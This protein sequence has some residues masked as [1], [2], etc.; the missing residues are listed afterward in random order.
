[1]DA[2]TMKGFEQECGAP[3]LPRQVFVGGLPKDVTQN[4]L[5]AWAEKQFAGTALNAVLVVDKETHSRPRGFGFITFDSIESAER[6]IQKRFHEFNGGMIEIKRAVSISQTETRLKRSSG[7]SLHGRS[8]N[9]TKSWRC[10][11]SPVAGVVNS[12]LKWDPTPESTGGAESTETITSK[13]SEG[14]S[15][16]SASFFSW[17]PFSQPKHCHDDEP[18]KPTPLTKSTP[19]LP[20]AHEPASHLPSEIRLFGWY[21]WPSLRHDIWGAPSLPAAQHASNPWM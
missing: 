18:S 15:A 2:E 1:M 14:M 3:R 5:R 20:D 17:T 19:L 12:E 11:R 9:C 4:V 21:G 16:I 8:D 7:R 6:A 13:P 10:S